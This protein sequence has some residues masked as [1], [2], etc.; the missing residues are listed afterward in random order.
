MRKNNK[1][2]GF[3]FSIGAASCLVSIVFFIVA[4]TNQ[5]DVVT[6]LVL[7]FIGTLFAIGSI[8]SFVF[9]FRFFNS[10]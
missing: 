3:L 9:S 5:F 4:I 1:V 6:E 7:Y 2:S 10:K 8:T